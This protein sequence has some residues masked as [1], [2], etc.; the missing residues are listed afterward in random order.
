MG[1]GPIG[2]RVRLMTDDTSTL[3]ER[4]SPRHKACLRLVYMRLTSKEIAAELGIGVGTVD[5]YIAE[6]TTLLG[7]RNRR[8][9]A[10]L[11]FSSEDVTPPASLDP[12]FTG[13]SSSDAHS[14]PPTG[15]KQANV[16]LNLLPFRSSGVTRNELKPIQR[17]F[18][19]LQIAFAVAISFGM[20]A[21]GLEVISRLFG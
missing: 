19:I 18:W 10:E 13:V 6:A 9:A 11:L 14:P 7:A 21:T 1:G 17:L 12:M 4:L 2:R 20:L 5:S 8:R 3:A 16:W 15:S